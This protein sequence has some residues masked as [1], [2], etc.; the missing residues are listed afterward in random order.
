MNDT[1]RPATSCEVAV[2]RLSHDYESCYM[3][4]GQPDL[5]DFMAKLPTEC[6]RHQ[7]ELLNILLL[8]DAFYLRAALGR[9]PTKQD[10][11]ELY[12]HRA[13]EIAATVIAREL[14][15]GRQLEWRIAK[16]R[17]DGQV[18][19]GS[20]GEVL[21]AY[22]LELGRHVALKLGH[23]S[24]PV[25]WLEREGRALAQVNHPNVL[26]ILEFSR[27]GTRPYMVTEYLEGPSL[28]ARFANTSLMEEKAVTFALQ[29]CGAVKCLHDNA[30][31]HRDITPNNILICRDD[32]ITLIDLGLALCADRMRYGN[33][34]PSEFWGT[35]AFMSPE[36]ARQE[37][38]CNPYA[39]DL[40]SVGGVLLWLL[41]KES[42]ATGETADQVLRNLSN[43]RLNDAAI[44]G[45]SKQCPLTSTVVVDLLRSDWRQR[46]SSAESL[47]VR[48]TEILEQLRQSNQVRQSTLPNR[49]SAVLWD[50]LDSEERQLWARKLE[51]TPPQLKPAVDDPSASL[52]RLISPGDEKFVPLLHEAFPNDRFVVLEGYAGQG[53]SF[54]LKQLAV[55][56]AVGERRFAL[57]CELIAHCNESIIE[58]VTSVL[59]AN[60]LSED[61]ANAE[62]FLQTGP[63]LLLDGFDELDQTHRVKLI[64]DLR[65]QLAR[66]SDVRVVI[67]TRAGTELAHSTEATTYRIDE[68]GRED[69]V[70]V[71]QRLQPDR[72]ADE[73]ERLFVGDRVGVREMLTTPILI[74][75]AI[76]HFRRDRTLRQNTLAV[77]RD[78]FDFVVRRQN[79]S[80]HGPRRALKSAFDY[81][82]LQCFFETLCYVIFN[83]CGRSPFHISELRQ[84]AYSTA[85]MM[86]HPDQSEATLG[87]ILRLSNFI[88]ERDGACCF[89]HPSVCEFHAAAFIAS[90]PNI[91]VSQFYSRVRSEWPR[92]VNVLSF[93]EDLDADRIAVFLKTPE[94]LTI[95]SEHAYSFLSHFRE[96][97]F[98]AA[99]DGSVEIRIQSPIAYSIQYHKIVLGGIPPEAVH[100]NWASWCPS[101]AVPTLQTGI[102]VVFASGAF[103]LRAFCAWLDDR[104]ERGLS[105]CLDHLAQCQAVA[106][107][108][109]DLQATST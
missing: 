76:R 92:W 75:G 38:D 4:G 19:A 50:A 71:A 55:T 93:L 107:R 61:E 28:A 86:G 40:F 43:H 15:E 104:L 7:P 97:R 82:W 45:L 67:T 48:L 10:L 22:D 51:P 103:D 21:K 33:S 87:D 72:A 101:V 32:H 8:T 100:D 13:G 29:L 1:L 69:F 83:R 9:Q 105:H 56:T 20:Q 46:M 73:L 59:T 80:S 109:Q 36:T 88:L 47:H 79:E 91:S 16:F 85:K 58:L 84:L 98:Q 2:S 34:F 35:P 60:G 5:D 89:L 14:D 39:S 77:Y 37:A 54:F 26:R 25:N 30:I 65:K 49:A 62:G 53:K 63:L 81:L 44:E 57:F 90:Q 18:S 12:P 23:L 106:A 6:D 78:L 31:C 94:L 3:R 64:A 41:T 17:I 66:F 11:L 42:P 70:R 68:L 52:L 74:A 108:R 99:K 27:V 102:P 96:F 24:A 95:T